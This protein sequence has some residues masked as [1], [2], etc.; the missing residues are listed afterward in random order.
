[1]RQRGVNR[2][3]GNFCV[4]NG[5]RLLSLDKE[6]LVTVLFKKQFDSG[7]GNAIENT[8]TLAEMVLEVWEDITQWRHGVKK[9]VGQGI[10]SDR[11]AQK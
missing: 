11:T 3:D 10:D 7:L 9:I 5:L 1:M 2:Q 4:L 8:C 6:R